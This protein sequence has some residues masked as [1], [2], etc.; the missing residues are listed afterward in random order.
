M[1][2]LLIILI[3]IPVLSYS[4]IFSKTYQTREVI[5]DNKDSVIVFDV[6]SE[7]VD[8]ELENTKVYYWYNSKQIKKNIGGFAGYLLHKNYKV[9]NNKKS[10]ITQGGFYLGTKNGVWKT[11]NTKG[12]LI[13]I[14]QYK[15]GKLDGQFIVYNQ[16]GQIITNHQFKEG[17]LEIDFLSSNDSTKIDSMKNTNYKTDTLKINKHNI[18]NWNKDEESEEYND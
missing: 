16:F 15:K 3:F 12:G 4:Q 13:S 8:F 14:K 9:F 6:I 1:K 5:I 17:N 2:T 7:K 10:L 18:F 11:W